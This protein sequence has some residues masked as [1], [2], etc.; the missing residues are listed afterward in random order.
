VATWTFVAASS[1]SAADCGPV[2][3]EV[4][5]LSQAQM[6]SSVTCLINAQRSSHGLQPVTPNGNLHQAAVSHSSEMIA[7]SYF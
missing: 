3:T 6:E 7:Q 2:N 5:G 4:T 1:A